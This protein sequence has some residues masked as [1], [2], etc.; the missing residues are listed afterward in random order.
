MKHGKIELPVSVSVY[1][2]AAFGPLL[3]A[4]IITCVMSGQEGL[5]ELLE[6]VFRWRVGP[7]WWIISLSPLALFAITL[8]VLR[9]ID[10]EWFDLNLLGQIEFMPDL[11]FGAFFLWLFT[12]GIGEETGWRGFALPRLQKNHSALRATLILW[13]FIAIWHAPA[14]FLVYDPK[15][16]PGFL[17]GLLAG[18]IVFT[19]LYNSTNG[20]ILMVTIFHGAFNFVAASK[21]SKAGILAAIIST[22]VIVWAVLVVI[23]FKPANLSKST[24]H[25]V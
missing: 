9:F 15:I 5:K 22:V 13:I 23:L 3:A 17:P 10:G 11:G 4:V 21:A 12:Y 18:A 7:I 8:L 6:R 1:Y 24:K 25:M 2:F 14:F 16:L 19:W 20:S